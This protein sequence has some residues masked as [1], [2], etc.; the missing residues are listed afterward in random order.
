MY[1]DESGSSVCAAMLPDVALD[2]HGKLR[3]Q[4]QGNVGSY[5]ARARYAGYLRPFPKGPFSGD[6]CQTDLLPSL[7]L[8]PINMR[9]IFSAYPA[10]FN[11]RNTRL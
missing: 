1:S 5:V 6:R 8:S 11:V 4:S 3:A 9:Y 10:D 2:S 7:A